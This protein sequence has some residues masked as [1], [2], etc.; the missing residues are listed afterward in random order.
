MTVFLLYR[1]GRITRKGGS[2]CIYASTLLQSCLYY[3]SNDF[4]VICFICCSNRN[5]DVLTVCYWLTQVILAT[6]TVLSFPYDKAAPDFT[7]YRN[8][9]G[10][11]FVFR[12]SL[13]WQFWVLI[14]ELLAYAGN[15][16]T[17]WVMYLGKP[18]NRV[19][20]SQICAVYKQ[21]ICAKNIRNMPKYALTMSENMQ[22]YAGNMCT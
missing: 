9:Y 7:H 10:G 16:V 21:E 20:I 5:Q 12:H 8:D 11:Q 14:P 1:R 2:V 19:T 4:E 17:L 3:S 6:T 18:E 22:K 15:L 13:F